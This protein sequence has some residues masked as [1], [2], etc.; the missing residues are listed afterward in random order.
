MNNEEST[1]IVGS[2]P[3]ATTILTRQTS[4]MDHHNSLQRHD[5]RTDKARAEIRAPS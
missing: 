5:Y 1:Q 4:E 2:N 3:T